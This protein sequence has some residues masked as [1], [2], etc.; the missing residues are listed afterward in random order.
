MTTTSQRKKHPRPKHMPERTCIGCHEIKPKR[1]LIRIVR[2]ESGS[3]AIDPTGK[4]AGRGVYLCK[5]KTCWEAG[6]KK[7][8]LDQA[9]RTKITAEDRRGLS[10]YGEMLPG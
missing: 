9:L 6:M 5:A 2:T 4:R 1:E 7:E 10:Q 3:V 8:Y